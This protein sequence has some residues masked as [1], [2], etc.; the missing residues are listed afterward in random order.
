MVRHLTGCQSWTICDSRPPK[1]P[2][3]IQ[4]S[5]DASQL[6]QNYEFDRMKHIIYIQPDLLCLNNSQTARRMKLCHAIGWSKHEKD[7]QHLVEFCNYTFGWISG[8]I[9]GSIWNVMF[10]WRWW[11]YLLFK[12]KLCQI[13][14]WGHHKKKDRI[15]SILLNFTTIN[16]GWNS[17][18]IG[19]WI[20]NVN[21]SKVMIEVPPL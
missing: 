16:F 6:S 3:S 4:S 17:G 13:I 12:A 18:W 2:P 19:R 15:N 9:A 20:W 7:W 1:T 14:V 11:G 21:V 5:K 10:W 8:W